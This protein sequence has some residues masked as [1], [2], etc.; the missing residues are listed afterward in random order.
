MVGCG[1]TRLLDVTRVPAAFRLGTLTLGF[2]QLTLL[3]CSSF[4]SKP[5]YIFHISFFNI[6]HSPQKHSDYRF[7][8]TRSPFLALESC[9]CRQTP[10][11]STAS[12][13]SRQ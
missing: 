4:A 2:V 3:P 8:V 5:R 1:V 13:A 12:Y 11:I 9:A 7:S 10:P 6:F